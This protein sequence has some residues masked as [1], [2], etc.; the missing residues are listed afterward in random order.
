MYKWSKQQVLQFSHS[1]IKLLPKGQES[2][3]FP[4]IGNFDPLWVT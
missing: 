2:D 4:S 3:T 1:E